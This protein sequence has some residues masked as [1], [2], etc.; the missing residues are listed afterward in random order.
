MSSETNSTILYDYEIKADL[1]PQL[2]LE[3]D[4][5]YIIYS[6]Y[7]KWFTLG[8]FSSTF[9]VQ[10]ILSLSMDM[11][12]SMINTLVLIVHF[13]LMNLSFP[14]NAFSISAL[15]MQIVT[16][17]FVPHEKL[18]RWVMEFKEDEGRI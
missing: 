7:L 18:N 5:P 3:E 1:P 12:W 4:E 6:K 11:L 15:F 16:F 8:V 14:G 17:D 13:P 9:L 2:P 10:L